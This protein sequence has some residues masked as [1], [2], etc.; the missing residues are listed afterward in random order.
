M[1]LTLEHSRNRVRLIERM[2]D[3]LIE[4]AIKFTPP[5][6][7]VCLSLVAKR[8][9]RAREITGSG[10]KRGTVVTVLLPVAAER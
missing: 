4:N 8:H 10:V 9:Y 1:H 2:L 7:E 6:N 5:G 3:N